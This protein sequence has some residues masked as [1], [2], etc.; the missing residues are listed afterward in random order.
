MENHRSLMQSG[1]TSVALDAVI[2]RIEQVSRDIEPPLSREAMA[3]IEIADVLESL[4][5]GDHND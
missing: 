1:I 5:P 3:L 2:A 4:R